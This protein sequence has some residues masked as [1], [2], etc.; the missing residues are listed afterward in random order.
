MAA[1]TNTHVIFKQDPGAGWV[2]PSHMEV[3]KSD[4]NPE[5]AELKDGQVLLKVLYLSLDPY[6]RSRMNTKAKSYIPPFEIGK[7]LQAGGVA[8]VERVAGSGVEG[9]SKGD[10]VQGF[11]GWEEYTIAPAKGLKKVDTSMQIPLTY[12]LGVLGMPGLTA[13]GGIKKILNPKPS[14]TIYVSGAAG[15]VGLVVGQVCKAMGCYV[16][17]SAGSDDKV[18]MLLKE[19]K[20]DA[21][22]NYKTVESYD[23]ALEKHCPKGIDG[24]FDNVGGE[25]LDAVLKV[26]N[27]HG[28]IAICGAISQYNATEPYG[29]KNLVQVIKNRL[30]LQGLLAS[31]FFSDSALVSDF[32]T[33][34]GK[35]VKEGKIIYKE[36]VVEGVEKAPEAFVGMLKGANTGKQIVKVAKD[37]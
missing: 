37:V 10:V 31:D 17:G 16:V 19:A 8:R 29:I 1:K 23:K 22:F 9:L 28:R 7:T 26:M 13:Y 11:L 4:F 36:H 33:T 12:Y 35:Y 15:A 5:T 25:M 20:F 6:M 14:E 34:V 21:A 3:V 27:T 30:L 32:F 2:E 18:E 24:Y